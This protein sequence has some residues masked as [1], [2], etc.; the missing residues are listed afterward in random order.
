MSG[1]SSTTTVQNNSPYAPAQGP[2]DQGLAD[3]QNLYNRG[4]FN[5]TPYQGDMVADADPFQLQAYGMAPGVVNSAMGG[6]QAAQAG[7]MRALDPNL[8]SG[9]FEQVRQNVIDTVMPQVNSAFAGS[10][11][12]GSTLHA[13]N[14]T[15]G[16]TSGIANVENQ[17]FQQGENRALQ[18]AGMM[19][20]ANAQML[21]PLDY[22]RA[23]GGE[24]Q[25]QAQA[26]I[27]ADVIRDQQMQAGDL[28][29]LQDYLA[30]ASGAGSAFGTQ[31]GTSTARQR[32]GVFNMLGFGLQAAPLVGGLF[33]KGTK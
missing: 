3:A 20:Q 32:P 1:Q 4:G 13:Q 29:A 27:Q 16:L 30:L 28:Q 8:R 14:L 18:A 21:Q 19:G 12:T 23:L 5:I 24:R 2:I 25:Q 9:A 33:G 10:G 7:L 6:A 26:E 17:A 15:H 11:M 31:S 22:L